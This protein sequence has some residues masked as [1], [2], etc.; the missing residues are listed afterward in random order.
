MNDRES[1]EAVTRF[2]NAYGYLAKNV[3]FPKME[4]Y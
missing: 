4:G 3:E 2:G 1:N